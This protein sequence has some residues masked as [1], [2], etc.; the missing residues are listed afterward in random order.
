M[1]NLKLI[2]LLMLVLSL[3]SCWPIE[4][5]CC[6]EPFRESEYKAITLQ[7]EIL[8]STVQLIEPKTLIENAGKIYI[9]DNLLFINDKYKGFHVFDNTNPNTPKKINFINIPGATD[10]A[11]RNNI[12]YVNQA[13]DLISL[14]YLFSEQSM[15]VVKRIKNVFPELYSPD[16]YHE[17]GLKED[18]IVVDWKLKK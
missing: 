8:E 3:N 18:E 16:G 2:R 13:T 14:E 17:Y 1:K 5:Q 4:E 12:I 15:S 7:R 10:M 6:T 11:I 9:K